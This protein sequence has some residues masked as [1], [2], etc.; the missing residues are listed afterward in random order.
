MFMFGFI[1]NECFFIA[2]YIASIYAQRKKKLPIY[3]SNGKKKTFL[4]DPN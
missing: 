4:I 2:I 3:I 1:R